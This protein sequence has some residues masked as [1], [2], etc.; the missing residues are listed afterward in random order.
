MLQRGDPV[1]TLQSQPCQRE[2]RRMP[3]INAALEP[4][5]RR[6]RDELALFEYRNR[7]WVTAVRGDNGKPVHNVLIVGGGQK[8]LAAV[9][10][11]R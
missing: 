9:C 1:V 10:A 3:L 2:F 11:L 7:A 4:L 6:A 5:A 8:G